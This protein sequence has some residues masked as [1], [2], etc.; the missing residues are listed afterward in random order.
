MGFINEYISKENIEKYDIFG[1]WNKFLPEREH[2]KKETEKRYIPQWTIDREREIWFCY[3]GRVIDQDLDFGQGTGEVIW[4]LNY[5]GKN[6]EVRLQRGKE[7]F[8]TKERP[9]IKHW[10][11]L[12][13]TPE[14]LNDVSNKKLKN[15]IKEALEVYGTN[16]ISSLVDR[17][18]LELTFE[19]F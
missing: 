4:Y 14:S 11:F 1:I 5:K 15:I 3:V 19:N 2:I 7:S 17:K 12:S 13:I 9:Y 10:I 6:L 18:N 8:T 16:G